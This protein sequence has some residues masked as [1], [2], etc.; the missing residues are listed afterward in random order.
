MSAYRLSKWKRGMGMKLL[1]DDS[2]LDIFTYYVVL[3]TR[4]PNSSVEHNT[5]QKKESKHC[6]IDHLI[7]LIICLL[8]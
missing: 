1:F 3:R 2:Y 8:T 4:E 7:H 5:F 6:K